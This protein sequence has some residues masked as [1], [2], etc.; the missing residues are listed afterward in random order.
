MRASLMSLRLSAIALAWALFTIRPEALQADLY[1]DSNSSNAGG[2][3]SDVA[4]GTWGTDN[5]WSSDPNGLA[6]TGPWVAD[7][8][9]VFAADVS[10]SGAYDVAVSG[11][12][13]ASGIRFEE[14]TVSLNGGMINLT[15]AAEI[16]IAS[17]LTAAIGSVLSGSA[18]L[19][20]S[21]AGTLVLTGS[22]NYTGNTALASNPITGTF[23]TLR[24]GASEVIPDASV[25]QILG[26]N[27][28][29]DLNGQTETVKSFA[30]V[31]AGTGAFANSRIDIGSGTLIVADDPGQTETYQAPLFASST[32]RIVKTGAGQLNIVSSNSGWDGEFVLSGGLLGFGVSNA[33]GTSSSGTAKLTLDGGTITFFNTGSR[34]IQT[35]NVDIT[36]S[37]SALMGASNL[38]LLGSASGGEGTA[39]TTLKVDNPTITVN[40]TAGTTGVFILRGPIGDEGQNRGFTKAGPGALTLNNPANTY[41]GD[42][43]IL[44][45]QLRIDDNATLGDG[46]GTVH[47][48]GGALNV[49]IN[50]DPTAS[51]V[52]N[53]IN[54]TAD[55][56]ISTTRAQVDPN[57]NMNFTSNSIG[58]SAGTL[59]FRND[60]A[61]GG[62]QTANVFEPQFSGSGFNFS[63]PIVI[64]EGLNSPTRTTRLNSGNNSGVQ[65]FSGEIS[66]PGKFRRMVGG[67]ETVL[68]GANSYSGGTEVEGGTLTVSGSAATLGTGDVS[69]TGGTL[70]IASGVANA[71][72]NSAMLSVS[73]TGIVNL[74]A[75]VNETIAALTLGG[76]TQTSGTYGSSAT[77]ATFKLDQY[78][79]GVG[80]VTVAATSGVAADFDNDGNVDGDDLTAWKAGFGVGTTKAQGDADGDVDV[81]GADFLIWQQQVGSGLTVAAA[82][83]VPEPAALGVAMIGLAILMGSRAGRR[84]Q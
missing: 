64:A 28:I 39:I 26:Q 8:T 42:T 74:G 53:P 79:S 36:D 23:N 29:F 75:G 56:T 24:L 27:S 11:A 50:R 65:T 17:G 40:N 12:Q 77:S 63:R 38:E 3:A 62:T 58:G 18:G 15:G 43:T 30:S 51:P 13:S 46:T 44:E 7:E 54:V 31:G 9:A 78:F 45:G 32:G 49:T 69:V 59:T 73:G 41:G 1:W 67:G 34:S 48:S 16:N 20:Q 66:G 61:A 21:G 80:I 76:A 70:S 72:A 84:Y 19:T 68:T 81:D 83:A 25:V 6:V 37:F 33:L 52:P 71:I 10:V 2:S 35:Q 22:N 5:F 14:G 47:L 82:S 60:A 55:S 57:V 4:P